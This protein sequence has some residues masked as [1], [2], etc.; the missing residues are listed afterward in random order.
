MNCNSEKAL[1]LLKCKIWGE[2]PTL[3]KQ[4]PN[5]VTITK[6]Q[7]EHSERVTEMFLKNVLM[8]IIA[9]MAALELMTGIL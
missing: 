3:G 8:L 5:F 9:L 1:Y 6:V 2:D 7:I 4:N